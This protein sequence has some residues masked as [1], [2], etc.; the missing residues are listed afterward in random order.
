MKHKMSCQGLAGST[1][2]EFPLSLKKRDGVMSHVVL[3]TC[4]RPF[5]KEVSATSQ[6][7]L[8]EISGLRDL[9]V[10]DMFR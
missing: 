2:R 3:K 6:E 4:N 1:K 5:R 7:V 9:K 8:K 10:F